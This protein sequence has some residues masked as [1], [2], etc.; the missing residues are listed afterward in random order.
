[1]INVKWLTKF[2][3]DKLDVP[4]SIEGYSR[5]LRLDIL[6]NEYCFSGEAHAFGKGV[7]VICENG[8]PVAKW[9]VIPDTWAR[10]IVDILNPMFEEDLRIIDFRTKASMPK[11]VTIKYPED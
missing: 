5:N 2:E 7:P 6:K 1:M 10:F 3:A 4:N 9:I 11:C 8:K